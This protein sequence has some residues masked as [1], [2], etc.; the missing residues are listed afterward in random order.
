MISRF[1]TLVRIINL[2]ANRTDCIVGGNIYHNEDIIEIP[3]VARVADGARS[4]AAA[5][6]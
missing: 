2:R 4:G 1:A 5:D 6:C 3:I